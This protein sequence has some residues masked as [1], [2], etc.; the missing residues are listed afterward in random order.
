METKIL[1]AVQVALCGIVFGL[2]LVGGTIEV[3]CIWLNEDATYTTT[4][5]VFFTVVLLAMTG[6]GYALFR[7]SLNEYKTEVKTTNNKQ[8]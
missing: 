1:Y 5:Q 6:L 2:A 7:I 4:E 3:G 8:L